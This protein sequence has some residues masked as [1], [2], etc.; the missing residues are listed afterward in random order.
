MQKKVTLPECA[1]GPL[2][3]IFSVDRSVFIE[4]YV[5]KKGALASKPSHHSLDV[6]K[7]L[8]Q[9]GFVRE[10]ARILE[11]MLASTKTSVEER[12]A[13]VLALARLNFGDLLHY[14]QVLSLSLDPPLSSVE[15][16]KASC[17]IFD[18]IESSVAFEVPLEELANLFSKDLSSSFLAHAN[19][20]ARRRQSSS[21][22]CNLA[23]YYDKHEQKIFAF[24]C[25]RD[26]LSCYPEAESTSFIRLKRMCIVLAMELGDP[27]CLATMQP[28]ESDPEARLLAE[29]AWHVYIQKRFDESVMTKWR[30]VLLQINYPLKRSKIVRLRRAG[31]TAPEESMPSPLSM[32]SLN[33]LMDES[34]LDRVELLLFP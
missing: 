29:M 26:A 12:L 9:D 24:R 13:A 4:N 6:A 34:W 18:G 32:C 27:V 21:L 15:V 7:A 22:L 19:L 31:E 25:Y 5:G 8:W 17:L 33:L 30:F 20:I 14:E 28:R 3:D 1:Q 11:A 16:Q 2:P 23:V 10:T